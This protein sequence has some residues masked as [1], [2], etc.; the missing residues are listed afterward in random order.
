M[1]ADSVRNTD[2]AEVLIDNWN[3]K[4]KQYLIQVDENLIEDRSMVFIMQCQIF[5]T[6]T[7]PAKY[8]SVIMST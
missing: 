6:Y 7:V 1:T 8:V 4:V 5:L 2:N 3:G